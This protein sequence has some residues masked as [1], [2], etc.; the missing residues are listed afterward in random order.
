MRNPSC[1]DG[2]AL[3]VEREGKPLAASG[4]EIRYLQKGGAVIGQVFDEWA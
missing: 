4:R 1:A 3:G 2:I